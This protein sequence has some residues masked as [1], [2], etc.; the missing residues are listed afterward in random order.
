MPYFFMNAHNG[1]KKCVE[2]GPN[3]NCISVLLKNFSD[4]L[5]KSLEIVKNL[6]T[7]IIQFLFSENFYFFLGKMIVLPILFNYLTAN[8]RKYFVE[9]EQ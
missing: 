2:K 5:K 8:F 1:E 7:S 9:C 3:V 4:I 6:V